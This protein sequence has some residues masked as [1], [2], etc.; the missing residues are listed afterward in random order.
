MDANFKRGDQI[1]AEMFNSLMRDH[2]IEVRGEGGITVRSSNGR[3][4]QVTHSFTGLFTGI[5]NGTITA[6]SGSTMGTGDV[7]IQVK[8]PSS[9]DYVDS[10][11]TLTCDNLS[12]TTGGIP[13]STWVAGYFQDDGTPLITT[14]DCGN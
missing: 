5:T 6:R 11:I 1:T 14:A 13:D 7:D 4:I 10:G 3:Q 8:D 2:P 12:S 9:G